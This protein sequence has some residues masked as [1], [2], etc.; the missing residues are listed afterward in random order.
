[1][2]NKIRRIMSFVLAAVMVFS[3]LG[4][5]P[6]EASAEDVCGYTPAMTMTE[7]YQSSGSAADGECYSIS[8]ED[9]LMLFAE[10]VNAGGSTAGA[11]FYLT[12]DIKLDKDTVWV[13]IGS[14][15]VNSFCG[16]FDGCG[17]A[18]LNLVNSTAGNDFAL[19]ANVSGSTALIK[20]LGVE[21]EITGGTGLAGIVVSLSAGAVKNCWSA[22][23]ISGNEYI[24]GIAAEV[25][26][27]NIE[28]C[29]NYGYISGSNGI[30]AI[31]GALDKSTAA[32]NCYYVYYSADKAVG[33]VA[34][35]GSP[36]VYRFASSS[37]EA[38]TEKTLTVGKEKTDDLIALLNAWIEQNGGIA[39]YRTW[40][41]DTSSQAVSRV[42]GRYP[43]M[44]FPGYIAP[45]DSIYTA[46]AS[47]TALYESNKNG[48]AG[49]FYSISSGTELAYFRD[50]VNAG[51]ATAGITF[52]LTADIN[53]A[54]ISSMTADQTWIPIGNSDK[55]PFKGIFDG[56]GYVLADNYINAGSEQ[57]LF[58]YVDNVDAEIKN[59]AATGVILGNNNVG[60]IVGYL[61]SGNVTNCWFAGEIN[62]DSRVGSI[63]GKADA[64]SIAN[65]VSFK[66]VTANS[67]SGGIV[68]AT[69]SSVSVKYCYYPVNAKSGCGD[70]SA[71]Q[72]A[73][74]A[75]T[76]SSAGFMLERS[77]TVGSASGIMLL[78]VLNHWVT[79]LALDNSY[80]T[81]KYDSSAA[82]I[83][84]LQGDHPT[85]LYP[86]DASGIDRVDEPRVDVDDNTNPYGVKYIETATMTE[87]Y[88]SGEAAVKGGHY[89]ISSGTEL[90]LLAQFVNNGNDTQDVTFYLTDDVNITI[91]DLGNGG[92]GWQPIG[93]DYSGTDLTT[94]A[95][96]FRGTFD[97]C[98]YTVFGLFMTNEKGDNL[99]LFGRVR[100][101]TIKNLG[102]VGAMVGEWNCGGIVGKIDDGLIEN[103]WAAVSIQSESETGG[104][105]GRIDHTTIRNCVSYGSLLCYGG[106]TCVAGGIFG[107]DMGKSVIENCYYLKDTTSAG[108]NKLSSNSTADI[109][110][111]TYGFE[112]DD[113]F[114]TLERAAVVDDVITTS[115]LD[116]LNAWVRSQNSV[117][118]SG[119]E[120]STVMIA[121]GDGNHPGHYPRLMAPSV[122]SSEKNDGY[123]GDYTETASVSDLYA[124]LSNG[125]D[126]GF[127][128]VNNLK[129]LEALHSY[130]ADGFKTKGITFFM[131]CDIDMSEKYSTQ[132]DR[133]W[134][135]IGD[136]K[137]PFQ[138]TFDGQGYTVKYIYINTSADDQGLFGHVNS[139][140]VIK[141][142]GICGIIKGNTNTGGIVGDFNFSTL[143]NCWASCEVTA[144]DNNAGGLVG[145]ANNGTIVNCT[146]YGVV[147]NAAQY[148]AIAGYAFG[149]TIKY[150]YYL[151]GT[152]QQA[153]GAA[154][155]PVVSGV[156]YFNGTS[157]ACILHE[158]VN[159]EG[160]STR[161]ALSALK[162]YVDAHS[163]TNYCYWD[164][165]NTEEYLA[166]GVAFFPVLISASNT[167]GENDYRKVQAYF[168]GKEYYS[169]VKAVKAANEAE[170]GGEITLA[171]NAVLNKNEDITLDEDVRILT[172]DYSLV[173]KSDVNV[174]SMQ[175]LDGMYIVKEGGSVCL[176]DTDGYNRFIYSH[177]DAD[178]SCAS[179]IYGTQSLTFFSTKVDGGASDAYDLH[180]QDGEFIVNSTLDS[181][182]P[183][184]IP[185]GSTLTIGQRATFNVSANARIRTTGGAEIINNGTVKIGN[186]TLNC[187]G[188]K[189]MKG[190]F[191]DDGGIVSLPFVYKDGYR[192]D[193]WSDG[194]DGTKGHP[195]G[196]TIT[197]E[198]PITLT[199]KWMLG[200]GT[201]PYPGDDAYSDNDEPIYNIPI[202]VIQAGGGKI[203]PDSMKA[204]K[205]EN[206]T[207][208]T[209]PDTEYYLKN[210]LVDKEAAQHDA[211]DYTFVSISRPHDI[212][213]LYALVTNSAYY[214]WFSTFKDVRGDQWFYNYVGY[215]VSAGMFTGVTS[216]TFCPDD[217]MT[218]EMLITVLWRLS[219]SP[220]VPGDELKFV[221]VPKDNY[222]YEAIRWGCYYGI[223]NGISQTEFGFEDDITRE[224]LVTFLFRYAKNYAGDDVSLY[225]N[226]NILGYSD[227]LEISK[228]MTQPF[229]WA[230]GAGIV[231]GATENTLDPKGNA[232]RAMVAAVLSR[233]CNK[234]I[235]LVPV[236]DA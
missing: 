132:T 11:T 160:T 8:S 76:N 55:T 127:Y 30:G 89:S 80:R 217:N 211:G 209:S 124:S 65:C 168:D 36:T 157:A 19:F 145:G 42:D 236:F 233:Y 220:I 223:V 25:I 110:S 61:V 198:K 75:F 199:A 150:C 228:G 81:W 234:F 205:G 219:G 192:F 140:A 28:N 142:L 154:S 97:G 45:V 193:G 113:Y 46:T 133:S 163:E 64:G 134:L 221:D 207:F 50:Y 83:A 54:P 159:V 57:G 33:T 202:T 9:E 232:S 218:R 90:E 125:V 86:G 22:V 174:F 95:Y 6:P 112:N 20:N 148:G 190:V 176:W 189:L 137:N 227:V 215:C 213:A 187:N 161:N 139:G 165:G 162:L 13:P 131:T 38:L 146:S 226:T 43:T 173:I 3:L 41:Y 91:N 48:E 21:G 166:M 24:G 194:T 172:G 175:Q 10:Y 126:G 235:N 109:M 92:D 16:V 170:S 130:V 84:R 129:D 78:N 167:M 7:L 225:D 214:D 96:S 200:V 99:G 27:G 178:A 171:L 183:H 149:T 188:G 152:C 102:V 47:M 128:S 74:V 66:E 212:T 105:A 34:S 79:Y 100:G 67:K 169:I 18:V 82:G 4:I 111:F 153:Y 195:G 17:F 206:L 93:R 35:G 77:V 40:V 224:Q 12:Q 119:W 60:G 120:N 39:A 85:Q 5:Q 155:A 141:N 204:A 62:A 117:Q 222:S 156:Q 197:A 107:D 177:K 103:C 121:A 69:S 68:G 186:V 158:K 44:E 51:Y 143:A 184:K 229:Q 118:Y 2:S 94:L 123:D 98:G 122:G 106:E 230:I 201:D 73:V 147:A 208:S 203:S 23:D 191:E 135:P 32:N 115:L 181:G 182:N 151:Y 88:N 72:T 101:G 71:T 144:L 31:A 87:L 26:G 58:G 14:S 164:V 70:T 216:T 49:G 179:A 29:L 180:L 138:G 108:Y 185:G 210:L 37:T 56:Q 53:M 104:I 196:S 231:N 114:C 136:A 59:V 15:Y 63:V 116:A 1:M 52:Y